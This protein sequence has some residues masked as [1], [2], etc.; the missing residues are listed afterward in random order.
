MTEAQPVLAPPVDLDEIRSLSN[1]QLVMRYRRSIGG[2][3]SRAFELDDELADMAFLDDAG[4]GR[5]PVRVLLGHLMDAEIVYTWRVRRT[6]WEDRPVL[7]VWDENAPID[8]GVYGAGVELHA[9]GTTISP[10]LGA[11]AAT[12][13]T[14]RSMM[15][16]T[17]VQL[18]PDAWRR[19]AMHPERG[20]MT[21]KDIVAFAV[22]HLEHHTRFLNA[23]LVKLLGPR[24]VSEGCCGGSGGGGVGG[25][26]GACACE[27]QGKEK[28]SGCCGG[29]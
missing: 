19:V 4:V 14:L 2:M 25:G 18:P 23:K 7:E 15:S 27:E 1:E 6:L 5:W 12:I 29:H 13:Y 16:Q 17:L 24:P 26:G 22:W 3:D 11:F 20:E 21:V 28:G 9:R 10:A 8:Q